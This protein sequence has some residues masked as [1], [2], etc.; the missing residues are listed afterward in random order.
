MLVQSTACVLDLVSLERCS[1]VAREECRGV[2]VVE[3]LRVCGL[4]RLAQG[5]EERAGGAG[6]AGGA[7]SPL[8]GEYPTRGPRYDRRFARTKPELCAADQRGDRASSGV[9]AH[10]SVPNGRSLCKL[11]H[12]GPLGSGSSLM[13]C[14]L[15]T[16]VRGRGILRSSPVGDPP[17]LRLRG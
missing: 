7:H 16:R 14:P 15:F 11:E 2:L 6:P 12:S 8:I 9:R 1:S 5:G 13:R 10:S 17:R 4:L 3:R